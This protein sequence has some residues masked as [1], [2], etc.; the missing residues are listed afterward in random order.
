MTF[1]TLNFHIL[2]Q[3]M[4]NT[5]RATYMFIIKYYFKHFETKIA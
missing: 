1:V 4:F 5:I 3:D 2:Q